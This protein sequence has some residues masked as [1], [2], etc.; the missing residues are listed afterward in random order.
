ME[1]NRHSQGNYTISVYAT[2]VLGETEVSDNT[3]VDGWVVVTIK[4]DV[5]GDFDV[6]IYDV[7]RITGIYQSKR[8]DP[9]F[10]P[11]SDLDDDDEITIYDVVRC[12]SHY[13]QKDP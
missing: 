10:N 5:D 8:G 11:N 9:E 2:P 7:V 3:F 12:T 13:G 4:G 1:H 6:D